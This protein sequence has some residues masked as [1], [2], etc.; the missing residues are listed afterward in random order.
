MQRISRTAHLLRSAP[1]AAASSSKTVLPPV[2]AARRT[3][4]TAASTSAQR[5]AASQGISLEAKAR[6]QAHVRSINSSA[7]SGTAPVVRP[8]PSPQFQV[9]P[10]AQP[11][12]S[13]VYENP[14]QGDSQVKNGLDYS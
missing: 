5:T 10:N 2:V 9:P 4:S 14:L 13:P 3:K 8:N 7:P 1:S 12:S 6:V 11:T